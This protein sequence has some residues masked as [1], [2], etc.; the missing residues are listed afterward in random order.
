MADA[1]SAFRR[2]TR[3]SVGR[4]RL[5]VYAYWET[6][7]LRAD[8]AGSRLNNLYLVQLLFSL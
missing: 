1:R 4:L 2:T 3:E 8:I 7:R 6:I 5:I